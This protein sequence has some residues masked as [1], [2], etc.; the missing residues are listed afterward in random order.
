MVMPVAVG[1]FVPR[2]SLSQFHPAHDLQPLKEAEG[3][4]DRRE[5]DAWVVKCP[6]NL[7]RPKRARNRGEYRQDRGPGLRPGVSLSSQ[8]V[9]DVLQ[10][11]ARHGIYCK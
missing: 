9:S 5:I 10:R 6:V 3:S 8:Q 11:L 1:E 2:G 7:L 4:I